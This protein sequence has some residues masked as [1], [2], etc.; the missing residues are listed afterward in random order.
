[1][2]VRS[3]AVVE[4]CGAPLTRHEGIGYACYVETM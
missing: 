3:M 2:L 1:M 4:V